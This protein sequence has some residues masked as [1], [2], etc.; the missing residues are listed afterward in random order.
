MKPSLPSSL[1][2]VTNS[3]LPTLGAFRALAACTITVSPSTRVFRF[4]PRRKVRL[5][6]QA[7][8]PS[9]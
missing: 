2:V 9:E 1:T 5:Q 6:L 7:Q 8:S 4:Q 3:T